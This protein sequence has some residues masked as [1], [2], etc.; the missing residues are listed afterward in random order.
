[1]ALILRKF[2]PKFFLEIPYGKLR[3]NDVFVRIF[4][5]AGQ[6]VY[7]LPL[8]KKPWGAQKLVDER[9]RELSAIEKLEAQTEIRICEKDSVRSLESD[10]IVLRFGSVLDSECQKLAKVTPL[11]EKNRWYAFGLLPINLMAAFV[12]E[13]KPGALRLAY[14]RINGEFAKRLCTLK[15]YHEGGMQ[16]LTKDMYPKIGQMLDKIPLDE[17]VLVIDFCQPIEEKNKTAL[18]K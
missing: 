16:Q 3:K 11:V 9:G 15:E 14:R 1:M 4:E 7:S 10:E 12:R 5:S 2:D 17:L 6:N 18:E 13:E 8:M